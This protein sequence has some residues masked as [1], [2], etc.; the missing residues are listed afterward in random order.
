MAEVPALSHRP[1]QSRRL[2]L[3]RVGAVDAVGLEARAAELA[4][5]SLDHEAELWALALTVRVSELAAIESTATPDRVEQLC[6][7]AVRPDPADA[8]VPPVA[9]VCVRPALAAVCRES[10]RHTDVAVVGVGAAAAGVAEVELP[11][12]GGAFV[13]G[14]TG[15]VFE[16][17]A[18]AREQVAPASLRIALDTGG[19][20]G[21]DAVRRASLLVAGAG[22][23]FVA[24]TS[25]A[26]V[27][28][29]TAL[30]VLQAIRDVHEETGRVVGFKACEVASAQQAVQLAVLVHETLGAEWLTAARWRI[31]GAGLL[32]D[33]LT[34]LREARTGVYQAHDLY[35]PT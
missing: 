24:L 27:A 15:R 10:L 29:P 4:T 7:R 11:F 13:S 31:G 17:I 25:P 6:A 28:L 23:D 33:V 30:C 34:Q 1:E 26:L 18:S 12:D 35:A 16:A 21:Y 22:A 3:L 8:S 20:A 2:R 32:N 9:A 5:R 19:L 14:Q